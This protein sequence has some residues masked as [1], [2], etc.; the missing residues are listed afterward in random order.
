MC[1]TLQVLNDVS[2]G[3]LVLFDIGY[4]PVKSR[5][6]FQPRGASPWFSSGSPLSEFWFQVGTW[7]FGS[8]F[9]GTRFRTSSAPGTGSRRSITQGR[10]LVEVDQD[11]FFN[12]S[13]FLKPYLHTYFA[14]LKF[15]IGKLQF[16]VLMYH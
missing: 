3:L 15:K 13:Y 10:W 9:W 8:L 1:A 12:H 2:Q 14:Y 4:K 7:V 5:S 6:Q 16:L 11:L